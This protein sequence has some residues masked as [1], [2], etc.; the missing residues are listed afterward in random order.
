MQNCVARHRSGSLIACI[1]RV[2]HSIG[3]Y[4]IADIRNVSAIGVMR[5]DDVFDEHFAWYDDD[6]ALE[7]K[8]DYAPTV[9]SKASNGDMLDDMVWTITAENINRDS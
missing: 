7:R 6:E 3:S 4:G 1:L 2:W 9:Q 8:A 5:R